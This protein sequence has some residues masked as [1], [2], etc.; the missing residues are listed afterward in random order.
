MRSDLQDEIGA[1]LWETGNA[2][3]VETSPKLQGCK[4]M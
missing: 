1:G 3:A 2:G 4:V